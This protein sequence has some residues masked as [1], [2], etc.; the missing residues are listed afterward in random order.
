MLAYR[1]FSKLQSDLVS[2]FYT[3]E[4]DDELTAALMKVNESGISDSSK[5]S[6]KLSFLLAECYQNIIRHSEKPEIINKTN[7]KPKMFAIRCTENIFNIASSNLIL[8]TKKDELAHTLRS[9][10]KLSAEQLRAA[11][12]E[13]FTNNEFSE[14]GGGGLG[15]IEMARKSDY[16]LQFDFEIV[17]FYYSNFFMQMSVLLKDAKLNENEEPIKLSGFRE[18]YHEISE[19]NILVVRK[20][21]FSQQTILPLLDLLGNTN[22][23]KKRSGLTKKTSYLLIEM[24]QNISKHGSV[25]NGKKEGIF[26]ISL[27]NDKYNIQT[28]NHIDAGRSEELKK[29]L[30]TLSNMDETALSWAY[31]NKLLHSETGA[32]GS[33]GIGLIELYK[34]CFGNVSYNFKPVDNKVVFFS[35]SLTV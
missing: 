32:K 8:N 18:L 19:E 1:F 35:L 34:Y 33:A 14:K 13:A 25:Q 31:K 10:N 27:K 28:G 2:L 3:G 16:P 6:K 29:Q 20:G 30:E 21:D 5:F 15:F 12:M 24:L 17:N 11:Y 9:L 4:F 26:I 22:F 7:D 23:S